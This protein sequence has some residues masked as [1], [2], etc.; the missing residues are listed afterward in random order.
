MTCL[1]CLSQSPYASQSAKES[2]DLALVMAAF[3]QNPGL[4]F[5]DEGVLQLL[6][7]A[8]QPSPHKHIG[9]V[10]SALEMYDISQLWVEQESLQAFGLVTEQLSQPVKLI[11]RHQIAELWAKYDQHLVF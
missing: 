5:I 7:K 8:A 11:S 2:L 3:E 10:I 6:P 1:I 9:K 4:L